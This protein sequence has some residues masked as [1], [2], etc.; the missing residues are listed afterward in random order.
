MTVGQISS[1]MA[2]A[3]GT[4]ISSLSQQSQIEAAN[5][6]AETENKK[7]RGRNTN[8]SIAKQVSDNLKTELSHLSH[9]EEIEVKLDNMSTLLQEVRQL[10]LEIINLKKENFEFKNMINQQEERINYLE[11]NVIESKISNIISDRKLRNNSLI[12]YGLDSEKSDSTLKTEI[13]EFL[14]IED[15]NKITEITR[16]GKESVIRKPIKIKFS[17]ITKE[18][19]SHILK[20]NHYLRK[21]AVPIKIDVDRSREDAEMNKALLKK[22]Y[23][24]RLLNPAAIYQIRLNKLIGSD[25]TVYRYNPINKTVSKQ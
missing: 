23:E 15:N 18:E 20:S 21:R 10:H 11:E 7:K 13:Q 24:I 3:S 6:E 2:S 19:K 5:N 16:L 12:I 9:L 25:N 14:K 22:R 8:V 1:K 4:D 17:N